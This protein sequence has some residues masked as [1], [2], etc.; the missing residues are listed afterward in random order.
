MPA[1][2]GEAANGTQYFSLRNRSNGRFLTLPPT[3]DLICL[4]SFGGEGWG[5]RHPVKA[6]L[7]FSAIAFA[8]LSPTLSPRAPLAEREA[9]GGSVKRPISSQHRPP[10]CTRWQSM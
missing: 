9:P 3:D 5:G 4:S 6:L 7:A 10:R 2:C 1:H 8:P